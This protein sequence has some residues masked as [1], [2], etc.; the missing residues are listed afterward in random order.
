MVRRRGGRRHLQRG[1]REPPLRRPGGAA[2]EVPLT[3]EQTEPV[4]RLKAVVRGRVQGVGFRYFVLQKAH[5]AGLV[6]YVR[7]RV[8]GAVECVAEGPRPAL[9]RLLDQLRRGPRSAWI[10]RV[11]VE[12]AA[13]SGDLDRF[14]VC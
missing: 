5:E 6:G 11:D 3:G 14:D 9:E 12:W 1:H 10:E 13:A 4:A 8:D 2:R 7:N